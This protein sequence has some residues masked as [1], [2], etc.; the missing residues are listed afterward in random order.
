MGTDPVRSGPAAGRGR[1]RPS[2]I[3]RSFL[4]IEPGSY[5]GDDFAILEA[6]EDQDGLSEG[7]HLGHWRMD[8]WA[9]CAP[10]LAF[11]PPF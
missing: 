6:A 8:A 2:L 10:T 3:H 5:G 4:T 7:V 11:P 1:V 9:I